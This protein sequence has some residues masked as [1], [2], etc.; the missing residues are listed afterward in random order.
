M[1]P[2]IRRSCWL[3]RDAV[4]HIPDGVAFAWNSP[5]PFPGGVDSFTTST[6]LAQGAGA[7]AGGDG[8]AALV[9][10]YRVDGTDRFAALVRDAIDVFRPR[11]PRSSPRTSTG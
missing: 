4:A 9:V 6:V 1:R 2:P 11:R 3:Q 7:A 5:S 10:R 8:A